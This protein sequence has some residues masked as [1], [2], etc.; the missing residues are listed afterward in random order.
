MDEIVNVTVQRLKE[1][2]RQALEQ[3]YR[4]YLKNY[5][6]H[7]NK[8][9]PDFKKDDWIII[10]KRSAK[11]ARLDISGDKRTLPRKWTYQWIG[12]GRYIREISNTEAEVNVYGERLV[13]GYSRLSRYRPWDGELTLDGNKTSE[14]FFE[15]EERKI[16]EIEKRTRGGR[17]V[18]SSL[19]K[20]RMAG[21]RNKSRFW[22]GKNNES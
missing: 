15:N 8:V 11:E 12:P 7:Q 5:E 14:L 3:Q 10:Y 9:K 22:S 2:F 17:Y 1:A 13:I 19:G 4:A 20:R 16:E 21:W 18:C 6:L